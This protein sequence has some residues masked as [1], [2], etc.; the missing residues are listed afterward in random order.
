MYIPQSFKEESIPVLH[1]LMAQQGFATLVTLGSEGLTA[2]HIPLV[3]DREP[4]PFGVLRGHVSRA[5]PLWRDFSSEVEALAIFSGPQHYITPSWYPTKTE[6]GKVVPTWNYAV[7]HAHGPLRV[8][9]DAEWLKRHLKNLTNAH[10]SKLPTPW[11][12][13]DAPSDFIESLIK[14]IV[15]LELPIQRLEGKWKVSQNRSVKDR[16]GVIT[17]LHE[18]DTPESQVMAGLVEN[19]IKR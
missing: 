9:D 6:T 10:E 3:L 19:T 2:N 1:E 14:G 18:L 5:N 7:V 4:A 11:K 17:G 13:D 16:E 15:G 8:M 12:V